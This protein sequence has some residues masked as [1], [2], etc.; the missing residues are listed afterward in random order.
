MIETYVTT[1]ETNRIE[2][3]LCRTEAKPYIA[4]V[5]PYRE[6]VFCGTNIELSFTMTEP[7]GKAEE[8]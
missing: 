2:A 7:P 5:R 3:G 4:D 8:T 1:K 6:A